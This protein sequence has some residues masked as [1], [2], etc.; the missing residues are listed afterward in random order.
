MTESIANRPQ[1]REEVEAEYAKMFPIW[2]KYREV[3]FEHGRPSGVPLSEPY[4]DGIFVPQAAQE[5]LKRTGHPNPSDPVLLAAVPFL[6]RGIDEEVN[7]QCPPLKPEMFDHVVQHFFQFGNCVPT[8]EEWSAQPEEEQC[9]D[10]AEILDR[11][12]PDQLTE[13]V[14]SVL[15]KLLDDVIEADKVRIRREALRVIADAAEG[16]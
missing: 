7:S 11:M 15:P 14:R 1:T 4:N 3:V 5:A 8:G 6:V 12:S 10:A 16:K 13:L 2:A 9:S